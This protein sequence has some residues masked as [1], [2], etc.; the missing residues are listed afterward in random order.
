MKQIDDLYQ[1][2][3]EMERECPA[4]TPGEFREMQTGTRPYRYEVFFLGLVGEIAV[5]LDEAVEALWKGYRRYNFSNFHINLS[6]DSRLTERAAEILQ[7]RE[8][9]RSLDDKER[10]CG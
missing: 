8:R 4:P 2:I 3:R 6:R 5:F 10:G 7:W 1:E 9:S